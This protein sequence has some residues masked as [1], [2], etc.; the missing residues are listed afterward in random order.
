MI[1]ISYILHLLLRVTWK[2]FFDILTAQN[3]Q[4]NNSCVDSSERVKPNISYLH[5]LD[6]FKRCIV[7]R[8]YVTTVSH[9]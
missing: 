2:H 6:T 5:I 7:I 4:L 1:V 8:S 3:L 9:D